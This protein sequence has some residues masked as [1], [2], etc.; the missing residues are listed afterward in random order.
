MAGTEH[1][2]SWPCG[3]QPGQM[4]SCGEA[5]GQCLG[6]TVAQAS[7]QAVSRSTKSFAIPPKPCSRATRPHVSGSRTDTSRAESSP[8]PIVAGKRVISRL[9]RLLRRLGYW[10]CSDVAV[11]VDRHHRLTV[12]VE[13]QAADRAAKSKGRADRAG[14]CGVAHIDRAILASGGEI[15]TVAQ[16]ASSPLGM[17]LT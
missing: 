9:D 10:P 16:N 5:I 12:N 8:S 1:G 6:V 11:F 4:P 3:D 14:R 13:R 17:S 15:H 2:V 7:C